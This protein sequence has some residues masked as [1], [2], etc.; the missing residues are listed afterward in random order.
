MPNVATAAVAAVVM[1]LAVARPA[2]GFKCIRQ[3]STCSCVTDRGHEIDLWSLAPPPE[4]YTP[5]V[6]TT[7]IDQHNRSMKYEFAPC[8]PFLCQKKVRLENGAHSI[9]IAHN[10]RTYGFCTYM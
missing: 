3:L 2:C 10:I 7:M 4:G 6:W 9:L 8:R 5:T 1:A